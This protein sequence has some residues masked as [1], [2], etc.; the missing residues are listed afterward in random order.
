MVIGGL[1]FLIALLVTA[2]AQPLARRLDLGLAFLVLLVIIGL[3]VGFDIIGVAVAVARET[4]Y[5]AMSAKKLPGARQAIRL[6]RHAPQVA[7]FCNDVVGDVSASVAGAAAAAIAFNLRLFRPQLKEAVLNALLIALVA[8]L[9]VGGKAWAKG[10]AIR[11][12]NEIVY[13]VGRVLY[14]LERTTGIVI[15]G[16][17]AS[18][19]SHRRKAR[20]AAYPP[21]SDRRNGREREGAR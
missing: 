21:A 14:W 19:E 1:A 7:A 6:V 15:P 17:D 3:G 13:Q 8:A 10:L 4:P 2:L 16:N 12:A 5:H 18:R 11:R 20:R 9:T